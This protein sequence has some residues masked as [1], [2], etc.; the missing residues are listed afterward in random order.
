MPAA[1]IVAA[2]MSAETGVGPAIASGSQVCR[3]NWADLPA[4]PARS[5]RAM[6]VGWSSPPLPTAARTLVMR[7][8][9]VSAASANRPIRKGTSP[10][11]VTRNALREAARASGVSQ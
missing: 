2:W 10:S 5:S 7:K 3:G 1:T 11:L 8:L 4:T 9:P 6:R